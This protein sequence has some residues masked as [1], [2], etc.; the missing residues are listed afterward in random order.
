MQ[1]IIVL[2]MVLSLSLISVC[3]AKRFGGSRSFGFSKPAATKTHT[4]PTGAKT[5]SPSK[6]GLLGGILAAGAIGALLGYLFSSAGGLGMMMLLLLLVA[7]G[8]FFFRKKMQTSKAMGSNSSFENLANNANTNPYNAYNSV[9]SPSQNRDN[10]YKNGGVNPNDKNLPDGT[11]KAV[12]EHQALNLFNQVQ[13][14]NIGGSLEHLKGYLTVDLYDQ[15]K[16]EVMDNNQTA[17]FQNITVEIIDFS[18]ESQFWL[19]SIELKGK[20]REDS[21]S[22]WEPYSEIWH[23]SR[24]KS[25]HIWKLSGIQ[26]IN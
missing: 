10:S 19:G 4:S 13:S 22:D 26:Q 3:E 17:V 14:L 7:F 24:E 20:V 16:S 23:F 15:I 12:F 11:P 1:K 6:K 9:A 8:I 25:E 21:F 18:D 5:Q 2:I